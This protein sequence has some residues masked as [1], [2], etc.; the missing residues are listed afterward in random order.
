MKHFAQQMR[1]K[2]R[3]LIQLVG[4]YWLC[5]MKFNFNS[6]IGIGKQIPFTVKPV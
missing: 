4:T 3:E 6:K 1:V 2:L 5:V